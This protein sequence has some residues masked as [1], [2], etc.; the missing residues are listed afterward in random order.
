[1]IRSM[2]GFGRGSFANEEKQICIEIKTVNHRFLDLSVKLPR[3]LMWCEDPIRKKVQT[4]ISR[5]KADVFVTY[6]E[7]QKP[8]CAVTIDKG[9]ASAYLTALAEASERYG[10][11]NDICASTLL[12]MPDVLTVTG[13]DMDEA[14]VWSQISAALTEALDN[15][16]AM[17]EREGET[18]KQNL[19]GMLCNIEKAMVTITERAPLIPQEY[20][21]KLENRLNTLLQGDTADP[22]RVAQE[23]AFFADRCCIDEEITRMGS[24]ITQFRHILSSD[25]PVGRKLDFLVQEMNREA[26]TM[27]SKAN[28]LVLT[29]SVLS[30]KSEIEKIREQIQNLE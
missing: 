13:A 3:Q 21:E 22:Q 4:A 25:E 15:L 24:H 8:G 27:G 26:N 28:D 23:V 10:I 18:L 16:V 1:M 11:T 9:L 30:V 29:Q 20:R 19:L 2:T 12:R 5:G 7:L 17:R 14:Q 6:T